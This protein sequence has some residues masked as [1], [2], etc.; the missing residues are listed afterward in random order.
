MIKKFAKKR[1]A[2]NNINIY[3]VTKKTA[4]LY[5]VK[6]RVFCFCKKKYILYI[7]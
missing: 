7:I 5:I 1:R 6:K 3:N 2:Y 4:Y